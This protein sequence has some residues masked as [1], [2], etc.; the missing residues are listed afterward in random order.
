[1]LLKK[2]MT[3]AKSHF[4]KNPVSLLN[5]SENLADLKVLLRQIESLLVTAKKEKDVTILHEY[6]RLTYLARGQFERSLAALSDTVSDIINSKAGKK[7]FTDKEASDYAREIFSDIA[8]I[9]GDMQR[10]FLEETNELCVF[11]D[12]EK[13]WSALN[14]RIDYL[15]CMYR[16]KKESILVLLDRIYSLEKKLAAKVTPL[17]EYSPRIPHPAYDFKKWIDAPYSPAS[18]Y[19]V[20]AFLQRLFPRTFHYTISKKFL[21][22]HP[23]KQRGEELIFLATL[24]NKG[25]FIQPSTAVAAVQR[26]LKGKRILSLGDDFGTLSEALSKLGCHVTGIEFDPQLVKM[27]RSGNYTE[28]GK[29]NTAVVQ[30]DVWELLLPESALAKEIGKDYDAIISVWLF[31]GGS[32]GDHPSWQIRRTLHSWYPEEIQRDFDDDSQ[33]DRAESLSIFTKHIEP[34]LSSK[35]FQLHIG[36]VADRV[37][38][39]DLLVQLQN[40]GRIGT[41]RQAHEKTPGLRDIFVFRNKP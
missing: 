5:R 4:E 39:Q 22:S 41:L 16:D 40:Q 12:K 20:N 25:K 1:M 38:Q 24:F 8:I 33:R 17:Q 14:A 6:V 13:S 27:A 7:A 36:S 21:S 37:M 29:P 10:Y 32:R 11:L 2:L 23:A 28:D 34:L 26:L 18:V 9:N 3:A 15:L 35:G 19:E 30:G 31:N